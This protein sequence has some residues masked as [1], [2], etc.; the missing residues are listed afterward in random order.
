MTT[1]PPRSQGANDPLASPKLK[2]VMSDV[3]ARAGNKNLTL[4]RP[5]APVSHSDAIVREVSPGFPSA[6][7]FEPEIVNARR[8]TGPDRPRKT[9]KKVGRLVKTPELTAELGVPPN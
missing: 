8:Q 5:I 6:S 7:R 4:T 2:D 3:G 9:P 1:S